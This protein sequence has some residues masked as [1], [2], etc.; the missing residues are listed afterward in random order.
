[1][2][3]LTGRI[4]FMLFAKA[5]KGESLQS[6]LIDKNGN[7]IRVYKKNDNPFMNNY[8]TAEGKSFCGECGAAL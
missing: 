2:E 1:M 5:T 4:E 8:F 3:T 6:F 7:K